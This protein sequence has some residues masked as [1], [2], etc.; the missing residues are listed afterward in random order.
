MYINF[1]TKRLKLRPITLEDADFIIDLLNSK[2]WLAFIG[3]RNVSNKKDAEN[4]IQ[5]IL[6]NKEFYY[7]IFELKTSRKA[8]GI[9]TF[10]KREDEIFPDIGFALLPEFEKKG[11]AFEASK[12]YLERIKSLN[13]YDNIIAITLPDNI[14]SINLLHKL[15]LQYTGNYKKGETILS[16]YSL[17]NKNYPLKAP[18]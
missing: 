15:G 2:G 17:N 18:D 3:D 14:K 8:I 1:E 16:Y 11:Y 13:R 4:Y 12:S 5:R 10:L 7:N 9:I 6:D